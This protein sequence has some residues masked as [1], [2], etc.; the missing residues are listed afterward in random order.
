MRA[1]QDWLTVGA[2]ARAADISVRTIHHYDELGLV[3]PS[4]RSEGG[5]RL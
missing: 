1:T 2:L 3:A 4:D 5:Y